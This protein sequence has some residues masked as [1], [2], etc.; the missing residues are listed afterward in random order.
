MKIERRFIEVLPVK[1]KDLVKI[2]NSEL[3]IGESEAIVLC[4]EIKANYVLLDDSK[5]RF[6]AR[7]FE[8]GVMGTL[9]IIRALLRKGII[10]EDPERVYKK[11]KSIEFW[12]SRELFSSIFE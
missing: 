2:L 9:G 5:A 4:R 8:I 7:S 3:G 11:L 1:N 6:C 12:I 10:R